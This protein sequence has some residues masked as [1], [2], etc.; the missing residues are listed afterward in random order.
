MEGTINAM[1]EFPSRVKKVGFKIVCIKDS[2][3]LD[4]KVSDEL[5]D[6]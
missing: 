2:N 4:L 6:T 3:V 1:N 5:A